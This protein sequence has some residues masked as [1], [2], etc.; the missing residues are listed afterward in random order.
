MHL[1]QIEN[2]IWTIPA[3]AMKGRKGAT[4]DFRV[5]LSVQ[6]L[7][8]VEQASKK[9][10]DGYVFPSPK[11]GVISDMTMSGLMKRRGM[12]ARPHGFRSSF[13]DWVEEATNTPYEVAETA[14]GHVVGG[15]VERAY[16]RTDH[17]EHRRTLMQ[18]WADYVSQKQTDIVRIG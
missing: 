15:I 14:L 5:P 3:E 1:D 16:R 18:R 4:T 17:I 8:V 13:R 10:R 2:D 11:R 6:A 7:A 12:E 9:A